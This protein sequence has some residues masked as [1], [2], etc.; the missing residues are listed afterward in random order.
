MVL[1]VY[2]K[3][4]GKGIGLQSVRGGVAWE[5]TQLLCADD[6]KIMPDSIERLQKLVFEFRY[7]CV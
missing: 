2:A 7:I 1:G 4:F 5:V 6:M 3:V